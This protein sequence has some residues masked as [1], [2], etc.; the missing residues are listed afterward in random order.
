MPAK[1]QLAVHVSYFRIEKSDIILGETACNAKS[2]GNFNVV[3][4]KN[5]RD[6]ILIV[7]TQVMYGMANTYMTQCRMI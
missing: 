4:S 3:D 6:R 1:W 5:V 7:S 2:H